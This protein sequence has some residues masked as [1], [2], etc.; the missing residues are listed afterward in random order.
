MPPA[1]D[2]HPSRDATG[3]SPP[4]SKSTPSALHQPPPSHPHPLPRHRTALRQPPPRGAQ[5]VDPSLFPSLR[6]IGSGVPA[7]AN[8]A[9][10]AAFRALLDDSPLQSETMA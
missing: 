9:F 1:P 6:S 3:A 8:A 5:Q 7:R 10:L 4:P 2:A